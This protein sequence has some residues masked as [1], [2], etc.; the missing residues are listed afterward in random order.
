MTRYEHNAVL[1]DLEKRALDR[2]IAFRP[3]HLIFDFIDERFDLLSAGGRIFTHSW[4]LEASGYR[5]QPALAGA[6][7]IPRISNASLALWRAAAAELAAFIQA[8]SLSEA[9]LILHQARWAQR[10][11]AADG[12]TRAFDDS[13]VLW[14]GKPADISA[15]NR[16]LGAFDERFTALHPHAAIVAAPKLRLADESHRWGLSPFH[17]VDAYYEEIWRQLQALGIDRPAMEPPVP[18]SAPAA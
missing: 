5:A 8:T 12:R 14:E 10:Y 17:Y 6:R 18:P 11:R 2:L 1:A 3:T 16:L 13:Y 4:E 9:R 7:T 15:H